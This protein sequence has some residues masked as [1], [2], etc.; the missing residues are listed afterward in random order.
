MSSC[1]PTARW[2]ALGSTVVLQVLDPW[3]LQRAIE[4]VKQ[5]L[6]EIDLA[7]SRFREDSE[8]SRV[9]R[10]GG[11]QVAI[12]PV[13]T[14]ELDIALRAAELTDGAVD[15]CVGGALERAGYDRDWRL[16]AAADQASGEV[17]E[18]TAR[19]RASWESVELD[20]RAGQ[21]RV[22]AGVKLD[23][24]ATAKAH[25]ADLACAAVHERFGAGVLVSLGGDIATAGQPPSGG[26]RIHVTDDHRDGPEA[27]GQRVSIASGGLATSSIAVRCWRRDGREMHH[28][29]D[30]ATE[31]PAD[32]PWR[33]VSVAA[34]DCADA[35]IAGTA[36]MLRG[37]DAPA[38]LERLGLPARL[39]RR[40]GAVV[41]VA[42]W[43]LEDAD[44]PILR[45][46]LSW[47]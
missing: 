10:A 46:Q 3:Q 8:L 1:V 47:A 6:G 17:L 31:Q 28:I 33:T 12:G 22:P 15:P 16:M 23:L 41:M 44:G 29:I 35:N 14:R 2:Q 45:E 19:R 40:D 26:W 38:W 32:T 39:V 7:C 18:V 5:A 24:G 11:S 27:P 42:G 30:P 13:L 4:I 43:P 37:E 20:A 9:N 21:V 36:A 34:A 25:A